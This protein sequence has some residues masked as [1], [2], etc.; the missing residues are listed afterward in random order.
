MEPTSFFRKYDGLVDDLKVRVSEFQSRGWLSHQEARNYNTMLMNTR[1]QKENESSEVEHVAER[2]E[3]EMNMIEERMKVGK[4]RKPGVFPQSQSEPQKPMAAP[5]KPVMNNGRINASIVHPQELSKELCGNE[6]ADLFVATC[7]FGRL[8]LVQ[9]PCCL[10]CTYSESMKEANRNRKC[11]R[12][13]V[14]RK[15]AKQVLHPNGLA[16]N[17]VAVRCCAA[18]KLLEGQVVENYKWDK[19]NKVLLELRPTKH[20]RPSK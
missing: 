20:F 13:V 19:V 5:L 8:G 9:P 18:R 3:R 4:I 12:W 10:E 16:S 1:T 7:F 6:I 11:G 15:N 14:W 2:L 17:A